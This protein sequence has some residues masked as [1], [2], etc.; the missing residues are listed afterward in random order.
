MNLTYEMQG[1]YN[2][3]N[4]TVPQ[5]P[6]VVIGKYGL[7][8]RRYL[9][10]NRRVQYTNLL[11]SGELNRHLLE[12]EQEAQAQVE[13]MVKQMAKSEGV[14]EGVTEKLKAADPLKWTQLMNN[15]RQA[16][17]ELVLAELIYR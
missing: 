5:E 12:V 14:T 9:K 1:D 8:R 15:L 16:A 6:E 2:L 17:E 10:E 3:P 7:L 11:T 13:Q 4:L